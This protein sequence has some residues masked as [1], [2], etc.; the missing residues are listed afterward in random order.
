MSKKFLEKN[1]LFRIIS[2]VV[3]T[4]TGIFILLKDWDIS[5]PEFLIIGIVLGF[6]G[7]LMAAVP[8]KSWS[9]VFGLMLTGLYC[10]LRSIGKIDAQYFR[11]G[12]G[13]LLLVVSAIHVYQMINSTMNPDSE[14]ET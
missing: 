9:T 3:T 11:Y 13:G 14:L 10:L 7:A 8:G 5:K 1:D 6:G 2:L 4:G 12:V